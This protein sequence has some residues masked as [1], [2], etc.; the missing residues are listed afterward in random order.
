MARIFHK[1][2]CQSCIRRYVKLSSGVNVVE[3]IVTGQH[4]FQWSVTIKKLNKISTCR[5]AGRQQA[6]KEFNSI[7]SNYNKYG[8]VRMY[9]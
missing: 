1:E 2:N 8:T 5:F 7:K 9:S 6:L 4:A 3:L